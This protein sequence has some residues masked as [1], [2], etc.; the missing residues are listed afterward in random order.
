MHLLVKIHDSIAEKHDSVAVE[1]DVADI[2]IM[3]WS[4]FINV[5]V[6]REA[7]DASSR[8]RVI[9]FRRSHT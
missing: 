9:L 4:W 7:A 3:W 5:I 2:G 8:R 1:A 6:S